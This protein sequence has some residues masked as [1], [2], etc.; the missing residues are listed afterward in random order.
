MIQKGN[1]S[2]SQ[3]MDQNERNTENLS[4][5]MNIDQVQWNSIEFNRI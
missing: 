2:Q 5:N 1:I 4:H 3:D